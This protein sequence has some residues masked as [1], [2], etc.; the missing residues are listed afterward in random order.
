MSQKAKGHV[1]KGSVSVEIRVAIQPDH[2]PNAKT[3]NCLLVFERELMFFN[4]KLEINIM[5]ILLE[6][7]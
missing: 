6:G 1:Y 3:R 5:P 2:D 4:Q 7:Q